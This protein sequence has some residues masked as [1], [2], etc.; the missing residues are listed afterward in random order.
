MFVSHNEYVKCC[1]KY[2]GRRSYH[3][4]CSLSKNEYLVHTWGS[5]EEYAKW[6][7][8][9]DAYMAKWMAK[10]RALA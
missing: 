3:P 7:R 9:F 8:K 2:C 6:E 10:D 1:S 5:L 4:S